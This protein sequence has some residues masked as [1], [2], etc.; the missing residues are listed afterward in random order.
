MFQY[1]R[2]RQGDGVLVTYTHESTFTGEQYDDRTREAM[3]FSI[4]QSIMFAR[5]A[6]SA[7][8]SHNGVRITIEREGICTVYADTGCRSHHWDASKDG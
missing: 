5:A 7:E 3:A 1:T 6:D 4:L 2:V 8:Y